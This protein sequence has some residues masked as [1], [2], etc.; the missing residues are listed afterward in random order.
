MATKLLL[1]I[2]RDDIKT[3][4]NVACDA[5]YAVLSFMFII[6]RCCFILYYLFMFVVIMFIGGIYYELL[7]FFSILFPN[8]YISSCMNISWKIKLDLI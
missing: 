6:I 1:A 7:N 3:G 5:S 2:C 8:M 4:S